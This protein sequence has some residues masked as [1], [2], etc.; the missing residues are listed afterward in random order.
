MSIHQRSCTAET[1]ARA[2]EGLSVKKKEE[3]VI[4]YNNKTTTRSRTGSRS[5]PS[6]SSDPV[7]PI[8]FQKDVVQGAASVNRKK[9]QNMKKTTTLTKRLLAMETMALALVEEIHIIQAQLEE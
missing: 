8:T 7:V 9:I 4:P 5:L 3:N 1:P 2:V 6:K